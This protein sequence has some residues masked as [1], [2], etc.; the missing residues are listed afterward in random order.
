M[1]NEI[2]NTVIG[3]PLVPYE[4]QIYETDNEKKEVLLEHMLE[5]YEIAYSLD[6]KKILKQYIWIYKFETSKDIYDSIKSLLTS[7][8]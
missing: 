5:Y 7:F 1:S 3:E 8:E 6:Y 2:Y 4:I